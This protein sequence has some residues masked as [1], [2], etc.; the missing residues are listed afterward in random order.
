MVFLDAYFLIILGSSRCSSGR[1][2]WKTQKE[3]WR[4]QQSPLDGIGDR[5]H[6]SFPFSV[7]NAFKCD[8][9]GAAAWFVP[10]LLPSLKKKSQIYKQGHVG[11]RCI[12]MHSFPACMIS[13]LLGFHF[14]VVIS[15]GCFFFENIFL[16]H[17]DSFL[18]LNRFGTD[19][20]MDGWM[21]KRIEGQMDGWMKRQS[22]L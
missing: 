8:D 1:T 7:T 22:L 14:S 9:Q 10:D 16:T 6:E 15:S 20:P 4:H 5:F 13:H 11:Q 2:K 18:C 17:L 19:Q 3:S 12:L 21:D